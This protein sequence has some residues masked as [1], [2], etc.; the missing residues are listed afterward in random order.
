MSIKK[1]VEK[2][3]DLTGKKVLVT[4]G[5]SGIGLSIVK[6]LLTKNAKVVVLARNEKKANEVK[7]NLLKQYPNN[8]IGFIKYDQSDNQS[9]AH[10]C[11]TI[12]NEHR[13]FFAL[14][15]NAGIF[16]SK[17]NLSYVNDVPLTIETNFIGLKVLLDRLLPHLEEE[18]RFIFQGSLAADW[19]NKKI[20]TLKD[21]KAKAF[22]Q[23]IISKSGVEALYYHYSQSENDLFSFYLV[24][25]GLSS[26]DIIREFPTPIRQM[27]RAFLK[28]FSH[29]PDKAALTAMLALQSSVNKNAYIV[30]RGLFTWS[31]YPKI[32]KFPRKRE[33][34]YLY[35]LLGEI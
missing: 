5:T 26:T 27:G 35:D 1:Y 29:S 4:G 3:E 10:A 15:M 16:Q 30:P 12:I 34:T 17:K 19:L 25:P 20:K 9:I 14:I 7:E 33:R 24:E 11:E 21:K 8:P 32:K 13:D 2:L 23:Y 22:K 6:H 18:H 28:I 31:G